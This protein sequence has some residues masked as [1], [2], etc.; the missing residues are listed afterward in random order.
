MNM[1]VWIILI[2]FLASFSLLAYATIADSIAI[3]KEK[4]KKK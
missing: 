1:V 2:L 3:L 4:T